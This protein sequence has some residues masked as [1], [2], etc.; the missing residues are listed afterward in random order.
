MRKN[1]T[2]NILDSNGLPI[3]DI[4]GVEEPI[5]TNYINPVFVSALRSSGLEDDKIR[6]WLQ[7]QSVDDPDKIMSDATVYDVKIE[8]VDPIINAILMDAIKNA[9]YTTAY[10][11][12][13]MINKKNGAY[14]QTLK[15]NSDEPVKITFG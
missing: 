5:I 1:N 3:T 8:D 9:D 12:L 11:F 7:W 13:D 15:V 10:R 2:D 14:Q 4:P 6:A